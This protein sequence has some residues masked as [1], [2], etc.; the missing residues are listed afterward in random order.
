M[1]EK[2]HKCYGDFELSFFLTKFNRMDFEIVIN[3]NIVFIVQYIYF[4][5]KDQIMMMF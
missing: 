2:N 1:G 4:F 5:F 3:S